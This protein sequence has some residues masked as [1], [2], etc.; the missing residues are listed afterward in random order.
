MDS[1]FK[2]KSVRGRLAFWFL[3]VALLPLLIVSTIIYQQRVISIKE[4]AFSKL[5]A[6]RDLKVFQINAWLDE[7]IGNVQAIS[8]DKELREIEQVVR[9]E[10]PI[11][12]SSEIIQTARDLL[13][14]YHDNYVAWDEI[15]VVDAAS[16]KIIASSNTQSE[17]IDK[18]EEL[19]FKRALWTKSAYIKDIYYPKSSSKPAMAFS[20]PIYSIGENKMIVGILVGL[21]DLENSLYNMLLDRTGMGQTGE[22]LIINKEVVALNELKWYQQAPLRLKIEAQPAVNASEG[23]IGIIETTDYRDVPVLAAYSYI[24][25]TQWGFVAKQDQK[26]IYAPIGSM[27]RNILILLVAAILSVTLVSAFVAKTIARP[28]LAMAKTSERMQEGDLFARNSIESK[29]EVGFLAE[30]FNNMANTLMSQIS[31]QQRTSAITKTMVEAGELN[32]FASVLLQKLIEITN[33]S[34]AAFY[35]RSQGGD[36]FEHFFSIGGSSEY[37][38]PFDVSALEGEFGQVLISK[39]ISH[40]QDIPKDT[41]FTIKLT[42]GTA[43]PRSIITIPIIAQSQVAAIISLTSLTSYSREHLDILDQIQ[44]PINTIFSNIQVSENTRNL[45]M[46]LKAKNSELEA[47]AEELQRQ[48]DELQEQNMELEAQRIQVEEANRLKSEFLSN[49]SHELRTPLNS[50]MA[51]SRVLIR[52]T[53]NNDS[54]EEIGFLEIIE[55]NGQHLLA[56]INDILDLSK[57]EA[58]KA[59]VCPTRFS[60]KRTVRNIIDSLTPVATEKNIE[61]ILKVPD[62]FP[63]IDNDETRVHQVLQNIIGN[64]VKFT[65]KG[66]VSTSVFS[67][68]DQV[69]ILVKDTGIGIAKE[70]LPHIFDE[71]RQVDGSASRQFEGT[72][73]GL[74]I[75]SK[76]IKLLGG[77]IFVESILHEGTTFTVTLPIAWQKITVEHDSLATPTIEANSKRKTVLAVGEGL[78]ESQD[79][80]VVF[81]ART[82]ITMLVVEDN[83][84]TIIQLKQILEGEGYLLDIAHD[85]QEALDYM[86]HTRPDGIIMDLMMPEVDGFAVLEKIRSTPVTADIPVLILTAKDLTKDDFQKLSS[87]HIRQL[88]Q[89]GDVDPQ[90]LLSRVRQMLGIQTI[91]QPESTEERD[92]APSVNKIEKNEPPS[93]K[94]EISTILVIEDNPGNMS[95]MKAILAKRYEILEAIDGEEGI[96]MALIHL[97]DLVLLDMSLPKMDGFTV[98]RKIKEYDTIQ[99]IPVIATTALAMIGDREKTLAAGC[100]EYIAKPLDSEE[101]L[102]KIEIFTK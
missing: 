58:G 5:I 72:G 7:R 64:A 20:I 81:K 29:D 31:I 57:I 98:V 91:I 23:G 46:E 37:F 62:D 49:M 95:A 17:G 85:G 96:N 99:H 48:S 69:I 26:E 18:S 45:A 93:L 71:F 88:V 97:P 66:H 12:K 36:R 78:I 13:L 35:V 82:G 32:D 86:Q 11:Q 51:L 3:G 27:V 53:K 73:L 44:I 79:R 38:E 9:Q 54:E 40:L 24:P 60:L 4:E 28:L 56:L 65:Q 59:E 76:A 50:I 70:D 55:R 90:E 21:V 74:T 1:F 102:A 101:L 80:P 52:R 39:K 61:M 67:S 15:F 30:S 22:T 10:V 92:A 25:R 75:A 84:A 87:N 6:I 42:S 89:K 68:A 16:G 33:S 94:K 83:E 34:V 47:L 2:F 63:E 100:D 14:R 77:D 43:V 8:Q 41:V 19:Y